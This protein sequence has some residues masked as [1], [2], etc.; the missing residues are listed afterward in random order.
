M[1]L[2][3]RAKPKETPK[4]QVRRWTSSLKH[5]MRQLDRDAR[6]I[7][8]EEA[9]V[10]K[11]LQKEAKLHPN[12]QA[13]KTL[14]KGLVRS[15]KARE[16]LME[17]KARLNSVC[18]QMNQ[19]LSTVKV[20][21]QM[22]KS[23][24]VMKAMNQLMSVSKVRHVAMEMSKE[25][26]KAGL[27]EEVHSIAILHSVHIDAIF[28]YTLF[29]LSRNTQHATTY[30]NA[31]TDHGGLLRDDGRRGSGRDRRSR[32]RRGAVRDHGRQA[33]RGAERQGQG[34]RRGEQ[35]RE[36]GVG[37]CAGRAGRGGGRRQGAGGPARPRKQPFGVGR[38]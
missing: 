36:A 18:L 21:G 12:S 7:E 27:M 28:G 6:K 22:Q 1:N 38:V 24:Q 26:T 17:S 29:G 3:G 30:H 4:E 2:F 35:A 23:A 8:R 33:G 14:A 5:E 16:N 31:Q 13:I 9:K 10:K 34:Q 37:G 25:M 20:V 15:R 19:V 32:G 11:E